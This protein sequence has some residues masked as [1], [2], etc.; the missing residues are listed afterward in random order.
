MKNIFRILQLS[1]V[2]LAS[3]GCTETMV[4]EPIGAGGVESGYATLTLSGAVK[5]R[6]IFD[7]DAASYKLTP[8]WE[9]GDR[10]TL[11]DENKEFLAHFALTGEAGASTAEFT[12]ENLFDLLE[13]DE[14]NIIY[15]A[16]DDESYPESFT[17][18]DSVQS[19]TG[20]AD[21]LDDNLVFTANFTYDVSD[22]ITLTSEQC[23]VVANVVSI[24]SSNAVN[25]VSYTIGDQSAVE[26]SLTTPASN[27]AV[28]F[29]PSNPQASSQSVSFTVTYN[30]DQTKEFTSL[31]N[32]VAHL[33]AGVYTTYLDMDSADSVT[34][35]EILPSGTS[36]ETEIIIP[37]GL[38]I[39]SAGTVSEYSISVTNGGEAITTKIE[40]TEVTKSDKSLVLTISDKIY[41]DDTVLVSYSGESTTVGYE[42]ATKL[43]TFDNKSFSPTPKNLIEESQ[44]D[45]YGIEDGG[46][47]NNSGQARGLFT[48]SSE[49][50][51]MGDSSLYYAKSNS[52]T[53]WSGAIYYYFSSLGS[54][55]AANAAIKN[56][57]PDTYIAR[58]HIFQIKAIEEIFQL[59]FKGY[60]AGTTTN[61]APSFVAQTVENS[62][63][64][65]EWIPIEVEI[66]L[67]GLSEDPLTDGIMSIQ[68]PTTYTQDT[69]PDSEFYFDNYCFYKKSELYRPT[70]SSGGVGV[71]DLNEEEF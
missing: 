22:V 61:S 66:D 16:V 58:A 35:I 59:R 45:V 70:E 8:S 69:A 56:I 25:S 6:V 1:A 31:S 30:S 26:V 37:L 44:L 67:T 41:S 17:I 29:I 15:P 65:N 11:F 38:S 52:T 55:A 40:V 20:D 12:A 63:V 27:E 21:H 60:Q 7:Y 62:T 39:E 54:Y 51:Y 42:G 24:G 3:V 57:T 47:S 9:V 34:D 10:I 71:G 48:I 64:T 28:I 46:V 5:S 4:D 19:A 68:F 43:Q 14:Y 50:A 23:V 36:S 18:K 33:A 13:G 2:I 32:S 49:K 53:T